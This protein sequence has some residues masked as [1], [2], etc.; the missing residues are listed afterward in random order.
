MTVGRRCMASAGALACA[1]LV[2]LPLASAFACV[3][4]ASLLLAVNE[5]APGDQV[6]GTG[7]GFS[8]SHGG[9][10]SAEPVVVHFGSSTGPILWAGRPGADH[11]VSFTFT[12]PAVPPGEYAVVATQTN[13]DGEPAPGTPARAVLTVV[14]PPQATTTMPPP[15]TPAATGPTTSPAPTTPPSTS[16]PAGTGPATSALPA[17]TPVTG[18]PPPAAA[19]IS[20]TAAGR[21][22]SAPPAPADDG[23]AE[24]PLPPA[25]QGRAAPAVVDAASGAGTGPDGPLTLAARETEAEPAGAGR[26]PPLLFLVLLASVAAAVIGVRRHRAH[27]SR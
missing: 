22:P 2:L 12:V 26:T 13:A 17:S 9:G 24:T 7:K 23:S 15:T 8:D 21:A 20:T 11:A 27:R 10:P 25:P 1:V 6:A 5:A 3:E 18:A 4:L 14:T 16:S 19:R